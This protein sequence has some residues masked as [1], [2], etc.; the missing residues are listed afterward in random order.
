M[1]S[2]PSEVSLNFTLL[3]VT[4]L[5]LTVIPGTLD[6][7]FFIVALLTTADPLNVDIPPDRE[8][9]E[10]DMELTP[11]TVEDAETVTPS[12]PIF[13]WVPPITSTSSFLQAVNEIIIITMT[14]SNLDF[15]LSIFNG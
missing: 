15:I 8:V 6:S 13:D 3:V 2:I 11:V 14:V 9:T 1:L 12:D 7:T 5:P 4:L 10:P